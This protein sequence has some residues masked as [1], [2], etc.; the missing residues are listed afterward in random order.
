[1]SY[2][3]WQLGRGEPE[4][5]VGPVLHRAQPPWPPAGPVARATAFSEALYFSASCCDVLVNLD[6]LSNS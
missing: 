6:I 1:M 4:V 3:S 2:P 5:D